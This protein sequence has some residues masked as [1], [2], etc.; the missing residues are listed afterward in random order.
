MVRCP[1]RLESRRSGGR[2][3]GRALA[4]D[5]HCTLQDSSMKRWLPRSLWLAAWSFWLWLGFGLHRELPR[6]VGEAARQFEKLPEEWIAG[7]LDEGNSI[8]TFEGRD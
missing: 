2:Q 1:Q 7:F 3:V 5:R 4:R 6:Q 8:V